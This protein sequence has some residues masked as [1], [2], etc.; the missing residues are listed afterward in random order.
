MKT[1]LRLLQLFFASALIAA[2]AV[3]SW[4]GWADYAEKQRE[5]HCE[6]RPYSKE[7][8]THTHA[9][10]EHCWVCDFTFAP[11]APFNIAL[12]ET[13]PA[14]CFFHPSSNGYACPTQSWQQGLIHKRG[15][16]IVNV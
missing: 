3:Q 1:R 2:L 9:S 4:H 7:S 16:P 15:P 5:R 14:A 11:Y 6:H 13:V 8:I 12:A 10:L